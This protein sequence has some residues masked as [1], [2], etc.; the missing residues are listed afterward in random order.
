MVTSK[1]MGII[2]KS[3]RML[4]IVMTVLGPIFLALG[5]IFGVQ[6]ELFLKRAFTAEATVVALDARSDSD[7]QVN[8]YPAF[9]FLTKDGQSININSSTGSNPAGY[10]IGERAK[11][12]YDPARPAD[13]RLDGFGQIWFIPTCFGLIGVVWMVIAA[14]LWFWNGR[15]VAGPGVNGGGERSRRSAA[16]E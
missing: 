13:A 8:Y 5:A 2:S 7:G 1:G 15:L 9:T 10:H 14:G 11:A 6:T 4:R 12:S 16:P 3:L